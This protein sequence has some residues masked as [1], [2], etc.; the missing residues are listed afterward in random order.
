MSP[1]ST[2][3]PQAAVPPLLLGACIAK[4]IGLALWW[5]TSARATGAALFFC[6][7]PFLLHA[8]FAPSGQGLVRV[9]TRFETTQPAVWLTIDDG[10]DEHDTRPILDLLDR[11]G[12]KATFFVIG[13]RAARHP[14]LIRE[15]ARRGHEVAHHT[16][17]HP[18]GS[19]WFAST[20]RVATELDATLAVLARVGVRPTR[21]RAP[22]G[23]KN[24]L[25][26][27]ALAVR[28]LNYIGW[29]LRSRDSRHRTPEKLRAAVTPRLVSGSILLFHEGPS[30]PAA[31]RVKGI[32]LLLEALAARGLACVIPTDAQLR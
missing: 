2:P 4:F 13:E 10:P 28:G 21:F 8:L 32:A 14:D 18:S 25:L 20:R 23:I 30:V 6:P 9:F 11:H 16:H 5:F 19:F 3:R 27:P 15:I 17:T 29:T 24:L 12:A 1:G 22:V 7:D 26:A 31:V